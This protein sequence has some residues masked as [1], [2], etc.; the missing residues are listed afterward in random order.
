M[1]Y[2]HY[3]SLWDINILRTEPIVRTYHKIVNGVPLYGASSRF[4]TVIYPSR[5]PSVRLPILIFDK[6]VGEEMWTSM[7]MPFTYQ[8]PTGLQGRRF[9]GAQTKRIDYA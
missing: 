7:A 2:D 5:L 3:V 6:K 1:P 9:I 4:N 8:R